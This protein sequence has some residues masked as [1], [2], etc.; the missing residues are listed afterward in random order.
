MSYK[1]VLLASISILAIFSSVV[2][3]GVSPAEAATGMAW[4]DTARKMVTDIALPAPAEGSWLVV[5]PFDRDKFDF[6]Y[7]PESK[8]GGPVGPK[9][10][11]RGRQA[12]QLAWKPIKIRK[13]SNFNLRSLC[14]GRD[15]DGTFYLA[16]TITSKQART[17]AVSM[18]GTN[19]LTV[20]INGK[21]LIDRGP[22][23]GW[24]GGGLKPPEALLLPLVAGEN[25]LLVKAHGLRTYEKW[26]FVYGKPAVIPAKYFY[27]T[28]PKKLAV[29][30]VKYTVS[31]AITRKHPSAFAGLDS[32]DRDELDLMKIWPAASRDAQTTTQLLQGA[33]AALARSDT[34]FKFLRAAKVSEDDLAA[35]TVQLQQVRTELDRQTAD[36]PVDAKRLA[37]LYFSAEQ[38]SQNL[39]NLPQGQIIRNWLQLD[40]FG[41]QSPM[42]AK[43]IEKIAAVLKRS[44]AL[45]GDYGSQ[46]AGYAQAADRLKTLKQ[47]LDAPALA[48]D[49]EAIRQLYI[50][51]YGQVR[52][53]VL[54][55]PSLDFGKMIFYKR[56]TPRTM[57]FHRHQFPQNRYRDESAHDGGDLGDLYVMTGLG[58]GA[59]LTP[60][61]RGRLGKGIVRGYD[62]SYDGR[63]VVF[64]FWKSQVKR[65]APKIRFAY[66]CY[67]TEGHSDIY[68]L[69]LATKEIRQL[70][71]EPWHDIDPCYLPDG[72]IAF[73]SERCGN[74]AECDPNPWS[75]AMV[76]LYTMD[77][78]GSDVLRLISNKDSD[79]FARVLNDGRIFYTHW[80]YHERHWLYTQTLWVS[81]PDGT[82]QDALFKQHLDLPLGIEEGRAIPGSEKVVAVATGHHTNPAGAI[83]RVGFKLGNSASEAIEIVTPGVSPFE[84]GMNGVPVAEGGV[85][86]YGLYTTPWPIS[87]KYFLVSYNPSDDMTRAQGYGIYLIDVFGNRELIHRDPDISCFSPV[88]LA[89]RVKPPILPELSDRTKNY[90]TLTVTDVHEGMKD[91]PRG[92]VKYLRINEAMP[93]PYT[94]EGASRHI[95]DYNWSIKRT[96]GLVPVEADG[97][98]HFVVPADIGIYFQA[99]DKNFMEVRRMRSL[100]SFQPGEQRSC[101]G[102]HET[103]DRAPSEST[104]LASRRA[105]SVPEA[106]S[107]GSANPISFIRDVQ[108]VLDRNCTR[109]HSGLNPPKKV[110]LFGG[111]TGRAIRKA[112]NT[113]Y[114]TLT[115]YISRSSKKDDFGVT[116]PYQF[117][118]SQSKVVK[119]LRDG[120]HDVKLDQDEWLRLLT[121]IDLNGAYLGSFVSVHDWYR[122][123]YRPQ[124][125]DM[126]AIKAIQQRRCDSCHDKIW[127]DPEN[128]APKAKVFSSSEFNADYA[129]RVAVDQSDGNWAINGKTAGDQAE[130]TLQWDNPV[131]VAEIVYV[132]PT[133]ENFEN[134]KNYEVYLD[135]DAAPAARGT[136]KKVCGPQRIAVKKQ[137]VQKV[138]L[139]FLNSYAP[140]LNP[141]ASIIAV[142]SSS[143]SDKQL[144]RFPRSRRKG[145]LA[146]PDWIHPRDPQKSLYLLAPLATKAG[147]WGKCSPE[148]FADTSDPDYQALL[149]ETRKIWNR[150]RKNPTPGMKELIAADRTTPRGVYKNHTDESE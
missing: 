14:P 127:K 135:E 68:E 146:Q 79:N 80:E 104:M 28:Y 133:T 147:G 122:W 100:V 87:E 92:T 39:E 138:R 57:N 85:G 29:S 24:L 9:V 106:P 114:N 131:E 126:K 40:Q 144:A 18:R 99:L 73:A 26:D 71:D 10:A 54:N 8:P 86:G 4:H 90:A 149:G 36:H 7:A 81:N 72:R 94:K 95:R 65:P 34:W 58:Q 101:I 98:A 66:D 52:D 35:A 110:D 41:I 123:G 124:L 140:K 37:G 11:Y 141:G 108:P 42:D 109:C 21:Q 64:G 19:G 113:S 129:A 47:R 75:E 77:G 38:I 91:V 6:P 118:S 13:D 69:D 103:K 78:N 119:M 88:P 121:W 5:G 56:Y 23:D 12:E 49:G 27:G 20:W 16:C 61:L 142:Y 111:L 128:L 50:D 148:V 102:C 76:N 130:F 33:K 15:A 97:S 53:L 63:R 51:A 31:K 67:V 132:G 84:G 25:R 112:H 139:K 1:K 145:G 83:V 45:L 105:P 30:A 70:T 136:L 117:G 89:S 125:A 44:R 59:K 55:N 120:H 116:Q 137:R 150:M 62:L 96:I 2:F 60:L 22:G 143:P 107:W 82:Q 115:K 43:V 48:G 93:W 3:G 134:W 17:Y 74:N 46:L 32:L